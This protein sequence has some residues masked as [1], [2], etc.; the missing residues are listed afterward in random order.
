MSNVYL[1]IKIRS[2]IH[3]TPFTTN[4]PWEISIVYLTMSN[5][6]QSIIAKTCNSIIQTILLII[7]ILYIILC[8]IISFENYTRTYCGLSNHTVQHPYCGLFGHTIQHFDTT[9]RTNMYNMICAPLVDIKNHWNN[10]LF[11]CAF[12]LD[13]TIVSFT[14]LFE[15]FIE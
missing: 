5:P 13:E 7:I 11:S 12:L 14:W 10:V 3:T 15:T 4:Y 8:K 1:N 6:I 9:Y 2:L